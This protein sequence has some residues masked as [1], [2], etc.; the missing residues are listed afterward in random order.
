MVLN[1]FCAYITLNGALITISIDRD[2]RALNVFDKNTI[3]EQAMP[4]SLHI[5]QILHF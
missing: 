2:E 4:K 5:I 3:R 1:I